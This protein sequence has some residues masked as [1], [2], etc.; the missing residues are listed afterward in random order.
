M[1]PEPLFDLVSRHRVQYFAGAPVTMNT[2]LAH[3]QRKKFEHAVEFWVAGAPPP[4]AV[5]KRFEAEI[6]VKTTCAYGLT[7]TYG[8]I[9]SH[10]VDQDWLAARPPP[11]ADALLMKR[12][13]LSPD[14][15]VEAVRVMD[16]E[17]LTPVPPDGETVGEVPS[18]ARPARSI[19]PHRAHRLSLLS[20]SIPSFLVVTTLLQVMVR[21]NVVM[22]G[23]LRNEKA[24]RE[25]FEGGWFHTGASRQGTIRPYCSPEAVWRLFRR[26][27]ALMCVQINDEH[28]ANIS[29]VGTKKARLGGSNSV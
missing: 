21:G 4:P 6:G 3:P 10:R 24:T 26:R 5:I 11:T 17:T 12:T 22:K 19:L 18:P 13:F 15:T 29:R 2:L 27:F 16:P 25:A 8:P 20:S 7:E 23:Y 28:A 9:C 1:R 14:A